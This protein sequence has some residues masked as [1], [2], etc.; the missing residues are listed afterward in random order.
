MKKVI[1][2]NSKTAVSA[3]CLGTM[4]FGSRVDE[5]RAFAIMEA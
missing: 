3:M 1:L 2:S 5:Q 4:Y